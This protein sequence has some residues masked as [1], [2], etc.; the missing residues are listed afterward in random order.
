MTIT[1]ADLFPADD[2]VAQWMFSLT[3]A[4]DDLSIADGLL[5][6]ALSDVRKTDSTHH[7]RLIVARLYEA[8]RL[9]CTTDVPE[10]SQFLDE[11]PNAQEPLERLR[12]VYLPIKDSAMRRTFGLIRHRTVHYSWVGGPEL[13]EILTLARDVE[14][15]HVQDDDAGVA[16][17][18]WPRSVF[19]RA[20]WGKLSEP[21]NVKKLETDAQLA[22]E[23]SQT[24]WHLLKAVMLPYLRLRGIDGRKLLVRL[25][26]VEA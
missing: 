5:H 15:R 7:F 4:V 19:T 21:A 26:D 1:V 16:Y 18:K 10:V 22:H 2:L 25:D 9:V 14:P 17:L 13:K 3:V 8:E 20:T 23:I 11:I 6:D 24:F 12:D